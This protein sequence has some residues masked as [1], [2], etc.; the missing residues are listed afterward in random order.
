[1]EERVEKLE[2]ENKE[3]RAELEQQKALIAL[4]TKREEFQNKQQQNIDSLTQKLMVSNDPS[5]EAE[6]TKNKKSDSSSM[7]KLAHT[8]ER[9][10][11]NSMQQEK[12]VKMEKYQKEQQ[13]NIVALQK[14]VATL[15]G[16]IGLINRWDFAACHDKLALSE[17]SRLVVQHN[18]EANWG[19]LSSVRA[20]KPLLPGN[21][22]FEV[23]VLEKK[24]DVLIGLA[25]KRMPLDKMVGVYEGTFGYASNGVFCG[26]EVDGCDHAPN[27]RPYIGGILPFG[28]GDVVGCGINLQNSQIIYTLDGKRL[29]IA[30]SFVNSAADLFPCVSLGEGTKIE[31]NF[32]PD[33]KFKF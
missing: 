26:H 23:E 5:K 9:R 30:N 32:G 1:M 28:V 11:K 15:S 14:T 17:L 25:T 12:V 21:P 8:N 2:H 27:G 33:F 18:G 6:L 22:Y 16:K 31:T 24:G 19:W 10:L 7:R 3:L 4:Q 29:D 13:L 20:E